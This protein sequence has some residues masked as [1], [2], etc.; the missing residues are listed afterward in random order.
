MET[1]SLVHWLNFTIYNDTEAM[2]RAASLREHLRR[3][4][5]EQMAHLGDKLVNGGGIER[6]AAQP[7]YRI[8]YRSIATGVRFHMHPAMPHLLVS[9]S[10]DACHQLQE[11]GILSLVIEAMAEDITRI[12]IAVDAKTDMT[13]SQLLA[14]G[15]SDRM[16][17]RAT[18]N[19]DSGQTEYLGSRSSDRFLR[20]YRYNPPHVRSDWLRVEIE[21]KRNRAKDIA[22][23]HRK[24]TTAQIIAGE[25]ADIGL[26]AAQR[27]QITYEP[28]TV[29][30]WTPERHENKTDLWLRSQ[31]ASAFR[32]LVADGIITDPE[33]YLRTH[34]LGE[35]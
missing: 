24:A 13:P 2:T 1:K 16:R 8:G 6:C 33:Q 22:K 18:I 26:V 7:P 17:T 3:T 28:Y 19:S 35:K 5:V 34:F 10:G 31:V 27:W 23:A 32:R 12:D 11:L 9:A 20:V 25:I 30:K 15:F 4:M 29:E 21:Y 14:H